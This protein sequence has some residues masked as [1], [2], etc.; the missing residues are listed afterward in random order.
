MISEKDV[1][2]DPGEVEIFLEKGSGVLFLWYIELFI[3]PKKAKTKIGALQFTD[4]EW[5][6]ENPH[7][8]IKN[9]FSLPLAETL[10]CKNAIQ[11]YLSFK[12]NLP[13]RVLKNDAEAEVKWVLTFAK[14]VKSKD[15]MV[16]ANDRP[17][18]SKD[19]AVEDDVVGEA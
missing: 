6:V 11:I 18:G 8:R 2:A 4:G 3:K 13:M 10:R 9:M 17:F 19:D 16:L 7:Q 14:P 5:V 12:I 15:F 1:G